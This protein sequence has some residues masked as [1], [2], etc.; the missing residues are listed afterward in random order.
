[1]NRVNNEIAY[2]YEPHHPAVVRSIRHILQ[3]S[4]EKDTPVTICGEIAGDPH[5]LP[6]LLG[7][8]VVSLS[9]SAPLI[10]ELKFFASRFETSESKE[11]M[12]RIL[13]F[14]RPSEVIQ[15]LKNFYDERVADLVD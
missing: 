14:R 3:I 11:L 13:S 4:N 6:L 7:M 5:F 9:A 8:G 10:P 15:S 12:D 1:M 2:L